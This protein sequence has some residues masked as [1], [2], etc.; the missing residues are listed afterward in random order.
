MAR[1]RPTSCWRA[2]A[3]L[4]GPSIDLIHGG[5]DGR[6]RKIYL[7]ADVDGTLITQQKVTTERAQAAVQALHRAGIRFAITSGR[8]PRGMAMLFDALALETPIA[9]FNGALSNEV[10]PVLA[11]ISFEYKAKNGKVSSDAARR[12]LALLL[13]VQDLSWADPTAPIK[14]ALVACEKGS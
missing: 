9:G 2:Q 7:V 5:A 6:K 3:A 12:A 14:T 11:E 4:G 1:Q 8:P 10:H 13:V